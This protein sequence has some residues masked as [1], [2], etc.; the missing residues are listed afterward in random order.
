MSDLNWLGADV[1]RAFVHTR[2]DAP[3]AAGG[4]PGNN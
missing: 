1:G 2:Q 4:D 3:R